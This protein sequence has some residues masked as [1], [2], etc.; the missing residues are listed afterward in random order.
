MRDDNLNR[1]Q[2]SQA[3]EHM[4][5]KQAGTDIQGC[6][7]H[8]IWSYPSTLL[9]ISKASTA[10]LHPCLGAAFEEKDE[11]TGASPEKSH[12]KEQNP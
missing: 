10:V 6:G 12:R 4:T 8:N 3:I 9:S 11:P 7:P 2:H 1:S 5:N